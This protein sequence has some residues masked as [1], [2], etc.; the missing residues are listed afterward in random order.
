MYVIE[1]ATTPKHIPST[2]SIRPSIFIVV[3][4]LYGFIEQR[5]IIVTGVPVIIVSD[6][7]STV[8]CLFMAELSPAAVG[9][10]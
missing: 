6:L 3:I 8:E 9:S 5:H 7:A 1:S 10:G 2:Q 4:A